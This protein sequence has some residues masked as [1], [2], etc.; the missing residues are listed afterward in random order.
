MGGALG[1][2]LAQVLVALLRH[3]TERQDFRT[4]VLAEAAKPG[5]E[6]AL[7]ALAWQAEAA[8]RPDGGAGGLRVRAGGGATPLPGDDP[9]AAR[10]P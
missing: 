8:G 6:A 5:N 2:I 7:A 10:R 9:D 1:A 3:F 4:R